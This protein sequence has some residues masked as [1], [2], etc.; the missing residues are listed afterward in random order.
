MPASSL[1]RAAV[2]LLAAAALLLVSGC[3]IAVVGRPSAAQ[4]PAS[5]IPSG[6]LQVVGATNGPID[7]LARNALADLEAY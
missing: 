6:E 1:R 5:D 3:S 7:T 4:P 2:A